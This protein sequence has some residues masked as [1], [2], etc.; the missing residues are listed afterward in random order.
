M[1]KAKAKLPKNEGF[2]TACSLW[3][4]EF[5][6]HTFQAVRAGIGRLL[7]RKLQ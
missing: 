1:I 5:G 7:E 2:E 6:F 3:R 4:M